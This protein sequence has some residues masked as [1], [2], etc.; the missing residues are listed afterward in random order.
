MSP[1]TPVRPQPKSPGAA[2]ICKQFELG[3]DA[4][5]LLDAEDDADHFLS[6]LIENRL[7]TDAIRFTAYRF[8]KREAVWWGC[9][10]A[11]EVSRPKPTAQVTA[12]LQACARWVGEPSEEG[13]LAAEAASDAALGTPAGNLA[14]AVFLSGGSISGPRSPAIAPGPLL[15]AKLVAEGVLL[16]SRLVAPDQTA[17]CQRRFLGMAAEISAGQVPVAPGLRKAAG[18]PVK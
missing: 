13:R 9:L 12:A 5:G 8:S 11:W 7:F 4:R 16:A 3:E 17:A 14:L 10:C 2:D 1:V 18:T 6:V 15:T